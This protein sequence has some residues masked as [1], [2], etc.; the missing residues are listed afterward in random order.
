[1]AFLTHQSLHPR[2]NGGTPRANIPFRDAPHWPLP[3]SPRPPGFPGLG[4]EHPCTSGAPGPH[5]SPR[6]AQ[7]VPTFLLASPCF[8]P[9]HPHAM[10]SAVLRWPRGLMPLPPPHSG[11]LCSPCGPTA[12]AA[13]SHTGPLW[14]GHNTELK[15]VGFPLPVTKYLASLWIPFSRNQL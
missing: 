14:L 11:V 4:L 12:E 2:G 9:S 10:L 6:S 7:P 15:L 3:P 8:P 5:L 1:M 13:S